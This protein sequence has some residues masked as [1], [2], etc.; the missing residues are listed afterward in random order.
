[1]KKS[2]ANILIIDDE[3]LICEVLQTGLKDE[4]LKTRSFQ[5]AKKGLQEFHN[6][7]YD[8]V[9]SD[10]QMPDMNGMDL[11]KHIKQTDPNVPILLISAFSDHTQQAAKKLGALDILAKPIDIDY[12]IDVIKNNLQIQD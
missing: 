1:M 7:H 9:I 6:N 3:V 12:V 5:Q 2:E 11:L 8:F 4:G 10:I